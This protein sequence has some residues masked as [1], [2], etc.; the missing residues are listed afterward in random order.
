M[1]DKLKNFFFDGEEDQEKE[2]LKKEIIDESKKYNQNSDKKAE[3]EI[4]LK[5]VEKQVLFVD[6]D[7]EPKVQKTNKVSEKK[8]VY[9]DVTEKKFKPSRHI[10]PIHGLVKEADEVKET[11]LGSKTVSESDYAKIRDKAYPT[12]VE[13]ENVESDITITKDHT[14]SKNFKIFKTSEIVDLKT[15]IQVENESSIDKNTSLDDAYEKSQ[16]DETFDSNTLKNDDTTT[17]DLFDLLD[18][19]GENNE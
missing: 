5:P 19:L 8:E 18:E 4:V 6:E 7:F 14:N 15:R 12:E 17:Q 1:I 11:V 9:N 13:D 10:S 3:S 16:N 2:K